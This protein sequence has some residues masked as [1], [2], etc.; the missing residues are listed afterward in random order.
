MLRV[1]GIEPIL[2]ILCILLALHGAQVPSCSTL[3]RDP[4]RV[5]GGGSG[6]FSLLVGR[7]GRLVHAWNEYPK[8]NMGD[9]GN[10]AQ[11]LDGPATAAEGRDPDG[12]TDV[13]HGA[14]A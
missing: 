11:Q 1:L 14:I 3:D 2:R 7:R 13:P 12:K 10:T 9:K 8:D 4:A 5:T 6:R